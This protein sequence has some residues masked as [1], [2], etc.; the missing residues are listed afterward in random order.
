MCY[1]QT[2]ELI[3]KTSTG[4]FAQL[5]VQC[6]TLAGEIALNRERA[7]VHYPS[8]SAAGKQLADLFVAEATNYPAF[9][10]RLMQ[11][12]KDWGLNAGA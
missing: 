7:G 9:H 12:R 5:I 6:L 3:L 4:Q 8:D 2:T 10:S 11:A 1:R